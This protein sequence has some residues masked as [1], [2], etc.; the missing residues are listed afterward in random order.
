MSWFTVSVPRLVTQ[1]VYVR[2]ET[3]GPVQAVTQAL[4]VVETCPDDVWK[5]LNLPLYAGE[6]VVIAG[7]DEVP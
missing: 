7:P 5:S 1:A 4:N 2:V 6:P 3:D